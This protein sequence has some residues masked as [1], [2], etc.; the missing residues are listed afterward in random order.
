MAQEL[1]IKDLKRHR[2]RK[3]RSRLIKK[4]LAVL[5]ILSVG[6]VIFF[7][8]NSWIPFFDGIA[9]RYTTATVNDGILAEGNF[10]I[11]LS[12]TTGY[13]V[14]TL[15]NSLAV[16]DDSHFYIY[17]SNGVKS[18]DKQHSF[19]K[20]I[21][22][23][24]SKKALLYDMNGKQFQLESKYKTIYSKATTDG[25]IFGRIA[26]ND[27]VALV[28]GSDGFV[29]AMTVYNST[30]EPF[31][32]WK[33]ASERIID[34]AFT[35]GGDGC[36]VTT[37]G[38]SGGRLVSK[39][40]RLSFDKKEA[41]WESENL[42]TLIISTQI[43]SDGKIVAFGDTQTAY[44]DKDGKQLSSYAY[45]SRF[46]DY[47]ASGTTTALL[48]R[49]DERRSSSLLIATDTIEKTIAIPISGAADKI[50]V[51]NESVL[52]MSENTITAYSTAGEVLS[53]AEISD[54]YTDF[55]KLGEH[56][57]LL[58]YTDIN[59]IDFK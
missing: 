10:P 1:D 53:S 55:Y 23:S 32:T 16:V 47:A 51:D 28:T 44:F 57:F 46:V 18:V 43:R 36:V 25:I 35:G 22:F 59:R 11:K 13:Q 33:S 27:N 5:L 34:V 8:R 30:G 9:T 19:G 52:I 56:I 6:G 21:L 38:A 31:Y 37:F 50:I 2:R 42:D 49:N 12:N 14:G 17:A 39:L 40:H 3:K 29:A 7:T 26:Q 45:S 58:G 48:F 54:E 20:P 41:V 24:N 4:L 15:E